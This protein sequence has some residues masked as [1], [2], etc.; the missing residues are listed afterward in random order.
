M[1]SHAIPSEAQFPLSVTTVSKP[2]EA[3]APQVHCLDPQLINAP[4]S[5]SL[6]NGG[7]TSA[8]GATVCGAVVPE[9]QRRAA[10]PSSAGAATFGFP[11]P[12]ELVRRSPCCDGCCCGCG[13]SLCSGRELLMPAIGRAVHAPDHIIHSAFACHEP[14]WSLIH[15]RPLPA[16]T[17]RP[18]RLRPSDSPPPCVFIASATHL[19]LATHPRAT[20]ASDAA[21]TCTRISA[22]NSWA[23]SD[24][25]CGRPLCKSFICWSV[26]FGR[27]RVGEIIVTW[28]LHDSQ[29]VISVSIAS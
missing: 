1:I 22:P 7:G 29:S 17:G 10:E 16:A 26:N 2:R 21:C 12:P 13:A 25:A 23:T 28:P 5:W 19:E 11:E 15:R 8:A 6:G 24:K 4:D 3:V 20:A 14:A 9:L 27:A 18:R